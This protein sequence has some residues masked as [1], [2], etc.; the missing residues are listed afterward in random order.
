MK[1]KIA[2]MLLTVMTLSLAACGGKDDSASS[3]SSVESGAASSQESSAASSEAASQENSTA[4]SEA[5][6]QES[7]TAGENAGT[8]SAAEI[9]SA[10]NLIET[11]WS[12]FDGDYKFAA[13]GGDSANLNFEGPGAFDATNSA[14]LDATLGFPAAQVDK[15]DDAASLMHMMNANTFTG[16]VYHLTDATNMQ[17][18]ADAMKENIM[19]RQWMCGFPDTLIIVSVDDYLVSAFG[20]AELIE[21]F[22]NKVAE[23][24]TDATLV[25]EESLAF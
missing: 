7:S 4:S 17:T 20:N 15:I 2:L 13:G 11:V 24:Y 6:S 10:L 12:N 18:V 1:K 25:Y 23:L 9:T 21:V 8:E 3:S 16:G 19:A 5:A 22:K 14:E